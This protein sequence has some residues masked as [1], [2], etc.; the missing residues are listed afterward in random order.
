M[1]RQTL[2]TGTCFPDCCFSYTMSALAAVHALASRWRAWPGACHGAVS[3]RAAGALSASTL[4]QSRTVE[5]VHKI[6][7]PRRKRVGPYAARTLQR[8]TRGNGKRRATGLHDLWGHEHWVIVVVWI[9]GIQ[10]IRAAA[11][12]VRPKH[13]DAAYRARHRRPVS[14][15]R[16]R[17]RTDSWCIADHGAGSGMG[18]RGNHH[19]FLRHGRRAVGGGLVGEGR[20]VQVRARSGELGAARTSRKQV[21]RRAEAVRAVELRR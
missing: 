19:G 14:V 10:I 2:T 13:V 21:K 8:T 15:A 9:H 5:A 3:T 6:G 12:V 20:M 7:L 18:S 16:Q 11:G 4:P 17:P 1:K